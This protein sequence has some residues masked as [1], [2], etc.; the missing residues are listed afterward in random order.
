MRTPQS[1][2]EVDS[3]SGTQMSPAQ[4]VQTTLLRI[5]SS[6][7]IINQDPVQ[8]DM[9]Y[10]TFQFPKH[11]VPLSEIFQVMENLNEDPSLSIVG[12]SVSQ[13]TLNQVMMVFSPL[14]IQCTCTH[15]HCPYC[16]LHL[17]IYNVLAVQ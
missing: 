12:Y 4:R 16:S 2:E 3:P 1:R 8:A 10:V 17:Y 15:V 7:R 11:L 13:S 6:D 9:D 14:H 5:F